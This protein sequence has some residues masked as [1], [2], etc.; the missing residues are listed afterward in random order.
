[1]G[2]VF[3]HINNFKS[4]KPLEGVK[5]SIRNIPTNKVFALTD[6]EG[7]FEIDIPTEYQRRKQKVYFS[8]DGF[9]HEEIEI[10]PHLQEEI[11]FDLKP[12]N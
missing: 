3:G 4:Q 1:M 12:K 11:L 5:V 7:Y 2:K 6:N 8:K 9:G 10:F